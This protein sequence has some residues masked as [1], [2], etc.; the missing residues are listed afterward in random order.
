MKK[1]RRPLRLHAETIRVLTTLERAGIRGGVTSY[2]LCESQGPLSAC[3]SCTCGQAVS[4]TGG[5][6]RTCC[7]PDPPPQ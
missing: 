6:P 2:E 3:L 5:N 7:W 1:M 4:S